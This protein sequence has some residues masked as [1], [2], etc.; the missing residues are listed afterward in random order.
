MHVVY[1]VNYATVNICLKFF[2]VCLVNVGNVARIIGKE[3]KKKINF[4]S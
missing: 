1:A 3:G 4:H 2:F